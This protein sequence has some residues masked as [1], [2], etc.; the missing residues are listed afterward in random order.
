M[1]SGAQNMNNTSA[2]LSELSHMVRD[3]VDKI[4]QQID[5]FKA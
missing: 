2:S 3:A 4:G 1:S 5:L